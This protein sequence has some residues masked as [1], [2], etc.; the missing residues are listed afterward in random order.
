MEVDIRIKH[1][2]AKTKIKKGNLKVNH[3]EGLKPV[4]REFLEKTRGDWLVNVDKV[5][6]NGLLVL[7][8]V[9]RTFMG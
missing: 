6:N 8:R 5:N 2:K 9:G 4:I 1:P 3:T 7:E